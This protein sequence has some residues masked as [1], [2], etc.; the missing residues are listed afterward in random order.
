MLQSAVL[1]DE[2]LEQERDIADSIF[3]N[4]SEEFLV[5]REARQ[6]TTK[7]GVVTRGGVEYNIPMIIRTAEEVRRN[8]ILL[9]RT[10]QGSHIG[11]APNEYKFKVGDRIIA[12]NK[13][14]FEVTAANLKSAGL[15]WVLDLQRVDF[16]DPGDLI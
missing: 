10:L 3:E 14:K 13:F 12:T 11:F 4:L 5:T 2:V 15:Y 8:D 6:K 7:R 9:G 16:G 1:S